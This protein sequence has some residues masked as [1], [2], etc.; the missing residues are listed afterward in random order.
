M[1]M[2]LFAGLLACTM[3]YACA[4][5]S[6]HEQRIATQRVIDEEAAR[7][8]IAQAPA[9][10]DLPVWLSAQRTRIQA[11]RAAATRDFDDREKTCW[12][13]FAVNDCL[14]AASDER[15]LQLD[16]LRQEDL[17]LNE[18][19]RQRAAAKRLGELEK[20]QRR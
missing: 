13:R 10:D 15:R 3:L 6:Q 5:S 18:L 8:L 17:A 16:R 9:G 11:S 4:S 14:R 19:E 2:R 20:K 1:N 12:R 7:A